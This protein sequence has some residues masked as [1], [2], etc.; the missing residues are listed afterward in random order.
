MVREEQRNAAAEAAA[1]QGIAAAVATATQA[2]QDSIRLAAQLAHFEQRIAAT[3]A[4][5]AQDKLRLAEM[6]A[7]FEQRIAATEAAAAQAQ[8]DKFRLAAQ[9]AE[10]RAQAQQDKLRLAELQA[11]VLELQHAN[12]AQRL[13]EAD[14]SPGRAEPVSM[15]VKPKCATRKQPP[16]AEEQPPAQSPEGPASTGSSAS[17]GVHL[18]EEQPS[19]PNPSAGKEVSGSTTCLA[20]F[21]QI[22]WHEQSGWACERSTLPWELISTFCVAKCWAGTACASGLQAKGSGEGA[23]PL[24]W[25]GILP[26]GL[27]CLPSAAVP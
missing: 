19:I 1:Q 5:V 3:E 14:A 26:L 9:L 8:E 11:Q 2:R 10:M 13:A 22:Q 27:P 16:A 20:V 7:H 12:V 21:R 24:S 17:T 4:A 23:Q 25:G 6:R 15:S 18:P